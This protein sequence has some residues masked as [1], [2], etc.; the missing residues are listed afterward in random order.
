VSGSKTPLAWWRF[1]RASTAVAF[2]PPPYTF[3]S[4]SSD[5]EINE[6][7]GKKVNNTYKIACTL[8]RIAI[9]PQL[10]NIIE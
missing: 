2:T 8:L 3:K 1:S 10:T 5:E 6:E 7:T 9:E 4:Y